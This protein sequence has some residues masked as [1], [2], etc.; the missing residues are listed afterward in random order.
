MELK[1]IQER[2]PRLIQR[3]VEV[4]ED[5]VKAT[6]L[7]LSP[8]EI[9]EIKRYV[10]AALEGVAHLVAAERDDGVPVAFMGI[11]DR[12]LEMLFLAP[13]ARGQGLGG[14][15]LQYGIQRYSVETLTVNEQ[16]PQARGFYEHMGF[17]V[18]RRTDLDEQGMPY[19]LLYMRLEK[20]RS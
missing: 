14:R 18:Y 17:R 9:A 19:P 11:Q 2:T 6:H 12:S 7:F 16:N 3:L 10:P 8:G 1:E 5:S 13:E 15:L 20:G 4:W